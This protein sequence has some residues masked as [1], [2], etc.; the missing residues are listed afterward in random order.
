VA[1]QISSGFPTHGYSASVIGDTITVEAAPG[2]GITPNGVDFIATPSGNVSLTGSTT[3]EGGVAAVEAVAQVETVTFAGTFE[4]ADTFTVTINGADYKATGGASGMG[5]T[6]YVDKNRVWSPVGSLWRYCM[7]DTP[8]VW[9]PLNVTVGNDAGFI[10]IATATEGNERLLV[11]ARYQDLAG[12]FSEENITLYTLDQDPANFAFSTTLE[13][14]GTKAPDSVLR[15]GNDD[16]FY[17]DITGVRSMRAR[18]SSDAPFVSDIGNAID[19][20]VQDLIATLSKQ[21]VAEAKAAIEP[22]TG[23]YWLSI[24]DEILVLSYFPSAKITAWSVYEPT[25]FEGE[26][27]QRFVRSQ[28]RIIARAGDYLYFYGGLTGSTQPED[29]EVVGEVQTAFLGAQTPATIKSLTGFDIALRNTW[30]CTLSFDPND[31]TRTIN[32]GNLSKTTFASPQRIPLPGETSM[33]AL[34]LTCSKG[35]AATISMVAV[36][37]ESED[38]PG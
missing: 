13:H 18:S 26:A 20:Y 5:R 32:V 6:A 16:V 38:A 35:G 22:K 2:T 9:D 8:T 21:Q 7:L 33:V 36:H 19:A 11:A 30:A 17:L 27:V 23:R 1:Q 15:Y 25:E 31:D 4:V 10:N 37:Y 28:G 24:G 12:I 3:V 34:N 14:T 29:D